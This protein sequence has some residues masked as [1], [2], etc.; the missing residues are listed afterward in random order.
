VTPEQAATAIRQAA[1]RFAAEKASVVEMWG[2]MHE[3]LCDLCSE[4]PLTGDF[5]V[6][7][8]ALEEWEVAV[9]ADRDRAVERLRQLARRLGMSA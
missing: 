5:P 1:A 4:H 8:T 7:F 6:L 3:H 9:G 2:A